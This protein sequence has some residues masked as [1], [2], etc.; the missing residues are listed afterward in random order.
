IVVYGNDDLNQTVLVQ[1]DGSFIFP[2]IGRVQASELTTK[3]L[4]QSLAQRLGK[5]FIRNPQVSVLVQEYRSKT[6][7][8][9]GEGA[10]PGTYPLSGNT[11][12]LE[13]LSKVG[14]ATPAAGTE[15]LVVR[16]RPGMSAPV[17]SQDAGVAPGIADSQAEVL[18]VD[19]RDLQS[20]R[21]DR[22]F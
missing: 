5:A 18:K 1:R 8:V 10:R 22:N 14:P 3:G 21:L 11:S 16:P 17:L 15:V 2:L 7:S 19:L 6:V 9:V 20:G 4:E 13:I 12:L